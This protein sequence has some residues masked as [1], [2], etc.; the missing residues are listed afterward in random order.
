[1]GEPLLQTLD[2]NGIRMRIATEGAGPLVLLCHGFPESW[3]S[4]RHQLRALAAAGYQ[5]VAPDMRGYGGTTAPPDIESYTLLHHVG[6][7][8]DLAQS[9]GAA[10]T[11]IVGHDWGALVA[12]TAALL[13]P[14]LFRAVIGMSVPYSPPARLDFVSA[15]EQ[16]G[17][18][19]FYI[20]YFQTPSVAEEELQADVDATIRRLTFS[21]SGDGPEQIVAG[22]M[23]P[24]AGLLDATVEPETLPDWLSADE[25][26]YIAEEFRRTGFRGGLNWYRNI[27]RSSELLA[28][29]RGL[30]IQQPSLFIAG[31]RDDVLKFPGSRF[32]LES[33][34]QVLPALRGCHVLDGAGHWIQ[35]ERAREV[36]DLILRFLAGL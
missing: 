4:W 8:V 12:W 25:L 5:A 9:L 16:Q 10:Q 36:N 35:R 23:A 3:Y 15:L 28:P 34:P 27:R 30:A 11:V 14:D 19:T 2:L 20:Q 6:D 17:I 33:L 1:M 31:A 13:R 21:M 29:W 7:M 22:I 32:R 26:R 18:R 24:G